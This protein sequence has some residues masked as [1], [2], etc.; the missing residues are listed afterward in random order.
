MRPL[1]VILLLMAL[2]AAAGPSVVQGHADFEEANLAYL[3]SDYE[4]ARERYRALVERWPYD[5]VLHYNLANAHMRLGEAGWA[6]WRYEMALRLKPGWREAMHNLAL[7]RPSAPAT[8]TLLAR[9]VV[10]ARDEVP[11]Q[12]WSWVAAVAWAVA[13]LAASGALLLEGKR[14]RLLWRLT[15]LGAVIIVLASAALLIQRAER[16]T[17]PPSIVV[18]AASPVRSGPGPEAGNV[19]GE[20]PGGTRV[21][22]V[23]RPTPSG[24]VKIRTEG[25]QLGFVDREALRQLKL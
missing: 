7:A 17:N 15:A 9:P 1:L 20:L 22:E 23:G 8:G 5:P 2:T 3:H 10:W 18:A 13:I 24:W 16:R 11:P 4:T 19:M 25:G 14:R 12:Q 6:V 21:W